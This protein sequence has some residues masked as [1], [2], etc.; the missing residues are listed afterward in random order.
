MDR[1]L[2]LV[3]FAGGDSS[4]VSEMS[5]FA[6]GP[7][8]HFLAFVDLETNHIRATADGAVFNELL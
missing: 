2:I 6:F 4:L 5:S 7:D 8:S 3:F 1:Y